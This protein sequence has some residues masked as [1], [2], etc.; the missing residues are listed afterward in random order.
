MILAIILLA[1]SPTLLLFL[2]FPFKKTLWNK[3]LIIPPLIALYIAITWLNK[4]EVLSFRLDWLPSLGAQ[5]FLESSYFQLLFGIFILIIGI[6]I[7]FFAVI[8]LHKDTS[9]NSWFFWFFVF[10]GSMLGIVFSAN[11]FLLFLFWELTSLASF[12]LIGHYH[13]QEEARKSAWEALLVTGGGGLCLLA[14]FIILFIIS[15]TANL[16][17]LHGKLNFSSN[18]IFLNISIFLII[19]GIMTKSAQYPFHFWL[20][21][22]MTA[23]APASAYLHSATMV[24][25]GVF[26]AFRLSPLFSNIPLWNIVL[27]I[28]GGFTFFWGAF[29]SLKEDSIKKALAYTTVSTLGLLTCLIGIGTPETIYSAMLIL[30]A[31]AIYKAGLFLFAGTIEFTTHNKYLSK[32][33][34]LWR[35]QPLFLI[36]ALPFLC[37]LAGLPYTFSFYTKEILIHSIFQLRTLYSTIVLLWII[38]G[39]SLITGFA[40]RFLLIPL[41]KKDEEERE[42][43]FHPKTLSYLLASIPLLLSIASITIPLSPYL[44]DIF[45]KLS[46]NFLSNV[47]THAHSQS[48]NKNNSYLML[49]PSIMAWLGGIALGLDITLWQKNKTRGHGITAFATKVYQQIINQL[50]LQSDRITRFF[51][52]GKLRSYLQTFAFAVLI[53]S[54]VA[55]IAEW[56]VIQSNILKHIFHPEHKTTIYDFV[57]I[58]III[59]G[60]FG[61]IF[62]QKKLTAVICLG[63]IGYGM[64]VIFLIYSAPDLA[65]TQFI[66]ETLTVSLFVFVFYHLP[67][68]HLHRRNLTKYQNGF[69]CTL[70]GIVMGFLT[71]SASSIQ[72]HPSISSY[73][74][75]KSLHEAHGGNIVNVILVDFRGFDTLGEITVLAIAGIGTYAL[76][77]YQRLRKHG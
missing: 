41:F 57:L 3:I 72:T 76:L 2:P 63:I 51:Q 23:P 56:N 73:F 7:H 1:F 11:L 6:L 52:N 24:K 30:F 18:P 21:D 29:C 66:I 62:A 49:L 50:L 55:M 60:I 5:L 34:G 17:E 33:K 10:M 37:S 48:V 27:V 4:E 44:M 75:A 54:L 25:A 36:I 12:F 46:E 9:L 74:T 68:Q 65:M 69:I 71:L 16:P 35:N 28:S 39:N 20:P 64:A 38:I 47:A 45:H 19:L 15:G 53:A 22:A 13:E 59:A 43:E 70:F 77:R 58:L 67:E 61:V 40:I 14:G 26:L 42:E 8:Y 31:H 32:I